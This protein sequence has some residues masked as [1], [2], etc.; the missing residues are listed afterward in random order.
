RITDAASLYT[1]G[2]A[3]TVAPEQ[4]ERFLGANW[5]V[6]EK[7]LT[8]HGPWEGYNVTRKEAIRFQTTAHT[9]SLAL[10]F[11]GTGSEQMTR[12]LASRELGGRLAEVYRPGEAVDLLAE[13][14]RV[15]AWAPKEGD[16]VRSQREKGGFRVQGERAGEVG[17]AFV[18]PGRG[19]SLTGG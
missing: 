2:A 9:L 18:P 8:D 19:A 14:A 1:L 17:I 15:F 11:L 10:G 7:L 4:V 3:Y 5:P 12:Y 16:V 13:E 6:V